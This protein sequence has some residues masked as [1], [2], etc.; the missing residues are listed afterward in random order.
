MG[1]FSLGPK[2]SFSLLE[3]VDLNG[4]R[5][6]LGSSNVTSSEMIPKSIR[7]RS[8]QDGKTNKFS[9]VPKINK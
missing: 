3:G 2:I 4:R 7:Y 8:L 1:T 5:T 6:T 9:L